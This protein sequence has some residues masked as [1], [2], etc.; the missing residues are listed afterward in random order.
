LPKRFSGFF[1]QKGFGLHQSL[2]VSKR[3][4]FMI[5]TILVF[6]SPKYVST[7]FVGKGY[8]SFR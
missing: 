2:F 8:G 7:P 4:G 1:K 5:E 6:P 3:F